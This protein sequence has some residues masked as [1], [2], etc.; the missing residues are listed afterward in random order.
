MKRK[1]H[2]ILLRLLGGGIFA[3]GIFLFI[4]PELGNVATIGVV[5]ALVGSSIVIKVI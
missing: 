1:P 5:L 2:T 4:L 3:V